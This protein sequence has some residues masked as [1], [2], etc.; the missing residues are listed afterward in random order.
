M[1][2]D[3]L[4]AKIPSTATGKITAINFGD[5]D[6]IPVGHVILTIDE[7]GE[8]ANTSSS[9]SGSD[10]DVVVKASEPAANN[11]PAHK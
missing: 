4:V 11:V 9:D 3:K 2:T 7:S 5:D 8:N 10:D 1:F 6:V